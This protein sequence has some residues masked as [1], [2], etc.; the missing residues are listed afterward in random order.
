MKTPLLT[1]L[2]VALSLSSAL[3]QTS[4]QGGKT[5]ITLEKI[6]IQ[7]GLVSSEVAQRFDLEPAGVES[8]LKGAFAANLAAQLSASRQIQLAAREESLGKLMKEWEIAEKLGKPA[9]AAASSPSVD[10]ANYVA[11]A[12]ITDLSAQRE[13]LVLG[14]RVA[15]AKWKLL[16]EASIELIDSKT[17]RKSELLTQR[18]EK[19]GQSRGAAN[20]TT[21]EIQEVNRDLAGQLAARMIDVLSPIR[22]VAVRS[23]DFIIDRGKSASIRVGDRFTLLEPAEGSDDSEAAFP[24]GEA[25]VTLVNEKTSNLRLQRDKNN[26]TTGIDKAMRIIRKN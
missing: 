21:F 16:I 5:L 12:K 2:L 11:S 9:E 18:V 8:R 7:E 17:G 13:T 4:S 19:S 26:A 6:D 25:V 23:D 22:I 1:S 3:S 24:V 10:I 20:F 15:A 14:G